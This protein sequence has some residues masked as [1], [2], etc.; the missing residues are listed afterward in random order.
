[1]FKVE[2]KTLRE[3]LS[4]ILS[5]IE[6]SSINPIHECVLLSLKEKEKEL[7]LTG[8]NGQVQ[9]TTAV[10]C[11]QGKGKDANTTFAVK[12]KKLND[13]M[14][15]LAEGT[16]QFKRDGGN[17]VI[18]SSRG[19]HFKLASRTGEDFPVI[20]AATGAG[21]ELEIE[22]ARLHQIIKSIQAAISAHDH[23]IYLSGAYFDFQKDGLHLVAT[24]GHRLATDVVASKVAPGANFILPRKAVSELYRLL[25]PAA[26][27]MIQ[28]TAKT[29][30]DNMYRTAS[31]RSTEL[32][33]SCQLINGQYPN[34]GRVI[35]STDTNNQQFLFERK[36]LL[37][38]VRQVCTIH[39]KPGDAVRLV[40][41]GKSKH[42]E[43]ST[44]GSSSSDEARVKVPAETA[45]TTELT[46]NINSTYLQ[47]LLLAFEGHPR[48]K[49]AFKDGQAS[50]LCLP[51][52]AKD[53][54]LQY[55]VM[56]V[57]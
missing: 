52:A 20:E 8:S 19:G 31:F 6:T 13:I 9:V 10:Q 1:M 41:D 26:E 24:D 37:A 47:E 32:Q 15:N 16:I 49:M 23:R 44:E 30:G 33:L 38:G 55:V 42:I 4:K 51:E 48:F 14:Q 12:A 25:D 46:C 18:E 29:G 53:N 43:L 39:D 57:R 40:F 56:P 21:L 5:V 2:Q 11:A 36:E 22:Q 34:Y 3:A 17:L 27:S 54:E 35:P 7:E 45:A 28:L 50:I